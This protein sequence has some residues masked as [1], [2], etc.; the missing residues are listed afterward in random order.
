[1]AAVLDVTVLACPTN[2]PESHELR[3][4][5]MWIG[6]DPMNNI[7]L[8]DGFVSRFHATIQKRGNMYDMSISGTW[9]DG[10]R[11]PTGSDV[12]FELSDGHVR[13]RHMPQATLPQLSH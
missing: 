10:K 3:L 12:G 7:C 9:L 5:S 6:R 1:M 2:E 11:L 8:N 13:T 4:T